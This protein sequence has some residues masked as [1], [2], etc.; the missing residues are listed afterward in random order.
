MQKV[1]KPIFNM[2]ALE[3][4]QDHILHKIDSDN[5]TVIRHV[6]VT[7]EQLSQWEEISVSEIPPQSEEE[8]RDDAWTAT[9]DTEAP[10]TIKDTEATETTK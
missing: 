3:T 4:D 9:E 2:W 6:H 1:F 10:E 8:E 7:D 5:Y